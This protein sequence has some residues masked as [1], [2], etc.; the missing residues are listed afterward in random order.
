MKRQLVGQAPTLE[1]GWI[2]MQFEVLGDRNARGQHPSVLFEE[3]IA[4]R[5]REDLL[6]GL[7]QKLVFVAP[8]TARDQ[9]LVDHDIS[10]VTILDEEYDVGDAVEEGLCEGRGPEKLLQFGFRSHE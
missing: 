4:E 8:A 1:A 10:T 9:G 5:R 7:A 6:G 3:A 2:E